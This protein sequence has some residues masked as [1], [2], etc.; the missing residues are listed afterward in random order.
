LAYSDRDKD[1]L[2]REWQR[3]DR[4]APANF[5]RYLGEQVEKQNP[6][7]SWLP[8]VPGHATLFK[9]MH[10]DDW[11]ALADQDEATLKE[12]ISAEALALRQDM[13]KK[14]KESALQ[15]MGIQAQVFD[16]A[17]LEHLDVKEARALLPDAMEIGR[18]G[19]RDM[20]EALRLIGALPG[21]ITEEGH[22]P[23]L[24]DLMGALEKVFDGE[25]RVALAAEMKSRKKHDST[26][27][28]IE[29][30]IVGEDTIYTDAKLL[31]TGE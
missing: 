2:F 27:D 11:E 30:E 5:L 16:S 23:G 20:E 22:A 14:L 13:F 6:D 10:E 12:S 17:D 3:L 18:S 28:I 25:I 29:G 31:D 21:I 8:S 15:K 9:W 26:D 24:G 19:V 1:R 4:P 7:F